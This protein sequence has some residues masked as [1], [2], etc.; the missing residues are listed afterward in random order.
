M[1]GAD[2]AGV[3]G[4]PGLE[5]VERLGAAH[6]A[7]GD[8]VGAQPERAA[9]EFGER[10]DA[11]LGAQRDQVRRAALEFARVLDQHDPTALAR[12]LGEQGV[13]ERGLAG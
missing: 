9:D 8:A 5:E 1:D 11:V 13:G 3:A 4:A 12:D 2:A 7:D 10:G 6:L